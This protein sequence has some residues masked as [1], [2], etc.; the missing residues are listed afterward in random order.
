MRENVVVRGSTASL[1]LMLFRFYLSSVLWCD[2]SLLLICRLVRLFTLLHRHQCQRAVEAAK[3]AGK[4]PDLFYCLAMLD[5]TVCDV[6][7]CVLVRVLA[8]YLFTFPTYMSDPPPRFPRS[9]LAS[10]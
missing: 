6:C 5:A 3:V 2:K 10:H 9:E 1:F 7:V 4:A 8:F